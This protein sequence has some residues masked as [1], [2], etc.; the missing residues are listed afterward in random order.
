MRKK[1]IHV[2]LLFA[3][4]SLFN[5]SCKKETN[6]ASR[7]EEIP[8]ARSGDQGHLKQTKTFSSDLVVSWIDMQ[9]LMLK[10]PRPAGI[11]AAVSDRAQAY[12]G[13]ALYESVQPGMP[14]YQS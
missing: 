6:E 10:G 9:L 4:V 3:L 1:S 12:C 11:G 8:S 14:S 7:P 5:F 13:I 2:V